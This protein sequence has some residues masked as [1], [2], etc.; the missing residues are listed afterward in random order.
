M[1]ENQFLY[2]I[3]HNK[4]FKIKNF[5]LKL[6]NENF[7]KNENF[8]FRNNNKT[9]ENKNFNINNIVNKNFKKNI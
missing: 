7:L 8:S 3:S 1:T 2:K 4:K 6:N 5:S 9:L